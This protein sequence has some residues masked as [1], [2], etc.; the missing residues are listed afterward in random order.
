VVRRWAQAIPFD[1]AAAKAVT[2]DLREQF[3]TTPVNFDDAS[4]KMGNTTIAMRR[5]VDPKSPGWICDP[6]PGKVEL[7]TSRI[8]TR[9][10]RFGFR[11]LF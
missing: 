2:Y 1:G 3:Q 4:I 11:L 7:F 9:D 6:E 10:V 5:G 8:A